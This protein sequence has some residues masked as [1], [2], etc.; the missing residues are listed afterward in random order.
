MSSS[1]YVNSFFCET[2]GAIAI[3]TDRHGE[4]SI[5]PYNFVAGGIKSVKVKKCVN[6]SPNIH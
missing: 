6:Y 5:P 1:A 4:T 3:E 2:L